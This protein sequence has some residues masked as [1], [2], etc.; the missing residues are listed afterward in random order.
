M[1]MQIV[2]T[3]DLKG[4]SCPLPI[5]KTAQ[6][7]KEIESG[8]LV[9]ALATDPGSVADFNAWCKSTGHELVEQGEGD[10]VFRFVIRKR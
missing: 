10:G 1:S 9:E 5:V 7:M 6:A 8:E 3:L 2:K 4:L